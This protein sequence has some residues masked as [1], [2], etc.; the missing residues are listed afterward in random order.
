MNNHQPNWSNHLKDTANKPPSPLVVEAVKH[1][2]HR[3]KAIDIGGG[4]LK[5][6]QYLLSQGF[7]TTVIDQA[8]E[9]AEMA[10][11]ID[12]D[13]LHCHITS[14]TDFIFPVNAFDLASAMY[15]L[16]F[17]G[18]K[19]FD[20]VVTN[21]KNSLVAG[22]IFVGNFFGVRD[23]W[24]N[25]DNI[26]FHTKEQVEKLFSDFEI[27]VFEEKEHDG[28]LANGQSKHWHVFN[29]IAKKTSL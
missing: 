8:K 29:M 22:G 13:K 14:F 24:S 19:D 18:N 27:V 28:T 9:V 21:I 17:N 15:A 2:V 25:R 20:T 12:S 26:A 11:A 4:A 3:N 1:V 16:P 23:E 5:D 10:Q 6:T 7:E